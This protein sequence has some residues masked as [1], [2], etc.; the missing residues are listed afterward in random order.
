MTVTRLMKSLTRCNETDVSA[1]PDS[2]VSVN[3][4]DVV[5][6]NVKIGAYEKKIFVS[7]VG[8]FV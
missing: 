6:R 7:S 8:S 3:V 2:R 5:Q 4:Q 1:A